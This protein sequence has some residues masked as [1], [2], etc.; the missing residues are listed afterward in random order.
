[1][2]PPK[3]KKSTPNTAQNDCPHKIAP[4][5]AEL[6]VT[7]RVAHPYRGA[8]KLIRVRAMDRGA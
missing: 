5:L 7:A 1:M 6:L 8:R 3:I 4:R 2:F